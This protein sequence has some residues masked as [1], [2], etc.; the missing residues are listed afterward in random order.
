[1]DQNALIRYVWNA[2]NL[3]DACMLISHLKKFIYLKTKKTAGTS[4]EVFLEP[5]CLPPE[6]VLDHTTDTIISD[7]GVVAARGGKPKGYK[8]HMPAQR[9]KS[10]VGGDVWNNYLKICIIRNPYDKVVSYFWMNCEGKLR[11]T[12][13]NEGF[14]AARDVFQ[15]WLL[16]RPEL[17]IDRAV[18]TIGNEIC[19]DFVLKYESL[20][21]DH[22]ALCEKLGI[23]YGPLV[24]LKSQSR[25]F[26]EHDYRD[27]YSEESAKVVRKGFMKE[28]QNFGYDPESWRA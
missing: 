4:V 5:Y 25:S 1:M 9:V 23:D 3:E 14:D 2:A 24:S 12:I 13:R 17:P 20:E 11:Q 19:A 15:H 16:V 7:A 22:K 6:T 18:Y 27:Y 26:R 21:E 10:L 28:F 8:N